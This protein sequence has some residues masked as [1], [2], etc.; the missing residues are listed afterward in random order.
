MDGLSKLMEYRFPNY[1]VV[2][3]DRKMSIS[4]GKLDSLYEEE[5]D[6]VVRGSSLTERLEGK[7]KM[8]YS[9]LIKDGKIEYNGVVFIVDENSKSLNL[10]DT[11]KKENVLSIPLS[12]GGCLNVNRDSISSLASAIGMFSPEDINRILNAITVDTMVQKAQ[13][14]IEDMEKG[15]DTNVSEQPAAQTEQESVF[16]KAPESVQIAWLDSE[17]AVKQELS[18]VFYKEQ[19]GYLSQL[20]LEQLTAEEEDRNQIIGTTTESAIQFADKMIDRCNR[21]SSS[22]EN[23]SELKFYQEFKKRLETDL[24]KMS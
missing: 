18:G 3:S 17:A 1:G 7:G 16:S 9:A 6:E 14:E 15:M 24:E 13:K 10:G 2:E 4:S 8:P 21:N 19:P 20:M 11:S 23:Q 5:T 22:I 12:G